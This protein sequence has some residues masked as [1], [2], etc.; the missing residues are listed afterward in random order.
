M[1]CSRWFGLFKNQTS[2]PILSPIAEDATSIK[3][4]W[5]MALWID[6]LTAPR[7]PASVLFFHEL[8]TW[9]LHKFK[10][11][12]AQVM[13]EWSKGWAYSSEEGPWTNPH[14]I[15][16]VQQKM[17][18]NREEDDTLQFASDTFDRYDQGQLFTSPLLKNLFCIPSSLRSA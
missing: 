6:I 14:F 1:Y 12:F 4:N 17:T 3:N 5:N 7:E 8:E 13:P 9:L 15:H 10:K 18:K 11:P 2:R 16:D